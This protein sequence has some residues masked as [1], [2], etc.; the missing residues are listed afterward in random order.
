MTRG[1][2]INLM[3]AALTLTAWWVSVDLPFARNRGR[4]AATVASA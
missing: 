3:L 2:K 4:Q 1:L